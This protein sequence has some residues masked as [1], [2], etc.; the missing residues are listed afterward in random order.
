MK[1]V[2]AIPIL[3]LARSFAVATP[4]I[5]VNGNATVDF[6]SYPANE[7][8]VAVFELINRGNAPL[9]IGNIRKTCGCA[10][11]RLEKSL[12]LP[13]TATLLETEIKAASIS[14]SYSKAIYVESNDPN[15]RFLRLTL[16]GNAVPLVKVMPRENLYFGSVAAGKASV[17]VFELATSRHGV[18]A[19]VDSVKADFPLQAVLRRK[20][21]PETGYTLSVTVVPEVSACPQKTMLD[22][23]IT[24]IIAEPAGWPPIKIT[25]QGRIAPEQ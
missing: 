21:D 1:T 5:A 25:L 20:P 12:L 22:A 14:G 6:G 7:R 10:E 13:G 2:F 24:I 15:Q 8:R 17:Y 16:A 18:I 9:R 4:V 11:T 3:I 19:A 23:E